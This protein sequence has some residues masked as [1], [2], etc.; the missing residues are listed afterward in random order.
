MADRKSKFG[1]RFHE[2]AS[3]VINGIRGIRSDPG[4]G[5]SLFNTKCLPPNL[6]WVCTTGSTSLSKNYY[7]CT[8]DYSFSDFDCA[9]VFPNFVS[10][11]RAT[12]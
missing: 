7:H 6:I 1:S 5:V 9:V 11:A 12:E 4:Y 8:D 10:L 2:L 3:S